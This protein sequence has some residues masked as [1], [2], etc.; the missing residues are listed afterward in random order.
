[1]QQ[2]RIR[3]TPAALKRIESV[4]ASQ[5]LPAAAL[6]I[7]ITGRAGGGFVY[8]MGLVGPG[9]ER[10]GDVVVDALPGVPV[11]VPLASVPYLD[12]I[13]LDADLPFGAIR[14]NNPNP[15]WLDPL[16]EAVQRLLDVEINPSVASHGGHID[17][18]DVA[19]GVAYIHMGGGCQGCGMAEVTLGQGVRGAILSTFSDIHEVRDTTDHAQGSN[20]YYQAAK[21]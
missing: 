8:D 9:E 19:D 14:V 15:L 1:V 2:P 5:K 20:P 4:R 7:A 21:K 18:L 16:A 12:N 11:H 6:R 13:E 10:P 3:A 17:L